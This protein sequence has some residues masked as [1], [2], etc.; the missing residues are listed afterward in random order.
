MAQEVG[1]VEET[2]RRTEENGPLGSRGD[3]NVGEDEETGRKRG[4][5]GPSESGRERKA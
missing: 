5:G 3:V 4:E 2:G 1:E